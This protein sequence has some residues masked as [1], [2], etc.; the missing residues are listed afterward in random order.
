MRAYI[1]ELYK[2]TYQAPQTGVRCDDTTVTA[3]ELTSSGFCG[4]MLW[5][6]PGSV[7]GT[8]PMPTDAEHQGTTEAGQPFGRDTDPRHLDFTGHCGGATQCE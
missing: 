7:F 4:P 8:V 3:P 5:G 6:R 1:A 2:L